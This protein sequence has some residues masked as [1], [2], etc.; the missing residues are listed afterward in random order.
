MCLRWA[1]VTMGAA[2]TL[3]VRLVT[4]VAVFLSPSCMGRLWMYGIG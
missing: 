4:L 1:S 3:V 2:E